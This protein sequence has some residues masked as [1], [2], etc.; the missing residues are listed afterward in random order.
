MVKLTL[1]FDI[2]HI[3]NCRT[4][5][6]VQS[7]MQE[8]KS[9]YNCS[10]FIISQYLVLYSSPSFCFGSSFHSFFFQIPR[11]GLVINN[12]SINATNK[13]SNVDCTLDR[14]TEHMG[15]LIRLS[16]AAFRSEL[17][18]RERVYKKNDV[19]SFIALIFIRTI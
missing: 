7:I 18:D 6:T 12:E 14:A 16:I 17:L 5:S 8:I 11:K 10:C 1:T 19:K 4:V 2:L 9:I 3:I 15:I 13:C